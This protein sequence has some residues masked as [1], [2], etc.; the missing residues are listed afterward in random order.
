MKLLIPLLLLVNFA[1][2]QTPCFPDFERNY[3]F[4]NHFEFNSLKNTN[5]GESND[6]TGFTNYSTN[7]FTTSVSMGETYSMQV[8]AENTVFRNNRFTAWID[9]NNDELFS[10]NEVVLDAEDEYKNEMITIPVDS[11][12]IGIR[13][14]RV[15]MAG[16]EETLD[17][18]GQYEYGESEDYYITITD[19]YSEPYFCT[20]FVERGSGVTIEDFKIGEISNCNS[21]NNGYT[22]YADSV[23]TT[24]L[25]IGKTYRMLVSKGTYAGNSVGFRVNI[26]FNDNRIFESAETVFVSPEGSGIVEK[27]VSIPNDTSIIGQHRMRVRINRWATPASQCTWADGETEDYM[28]NIVPQDST[29]ITDTDWQKI[30]NF[31][32][33]QNVTDIIE[34]Y[35]N[36]YA[37]TL[38]DGA[39]R[40]ARLIK[41]SKDGDTLWSKNIVSKD[42][43]FY[44][45]N[46]NE[47]NGGG[48]II[49]GSSSQTTQLSSYVVKLDACGDKQWAKFYGNPKK[50]DHATHAIQASDSNYVVL[51]KYLNDTSR[52]ALAKLDLTG[53][54]IWQNDYTYH[55][56]SEP[57][58][59]IETSDKGF[60]IT[61]YTY[62]PN[63]ENSNDNYLRSM[64]IKIDSI[65]NTEWEK[66]LGTSDTISAAYSSVELETGGFMVLT[67]KREYG[68]R[69][70]I[71]RVD[72]MGNTIFHKLISDIP[73][74]YRIYIRKMKGDNYCVVSSLQNGCFESTSML[75]LYIIDS[76]GTILDTS[77]I[78]D[79]YLKI[80]GAAVT[81]DNKL[82]V[83]GSK[84]FIDNDE[85]FMF[86]FNED[87]EFDTLY[88]TTLNY[89]WLCDS[90]VTHV[91]IPKDNIDIDL[92][93]TLASKGINIQINESK[94][95]NYVVKIISLNG[96]ILKSENIHSHELKNLSL[97]NFNAG[98]YIVT[99][100]SNNN[101]LLT[102]KILKSR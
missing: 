82:I 60:L 90:T 32:E 75:G 85:I 37:I 73:N 21:G 61:G 6:I 51:F 13:R 86:K 24:D 53:T 97:K 76:N 42:E 74:T 94:H 22:F 66:V 36:G 59:L 72:E 92:Y 8:A 99:I 96:I 12:Y 2:S 95:L 78:E 10:S 23:F 71:Y 102:R 68:E 70:V 50:Y 65:G 83:A 47:T 19:S 14:L 93:P 63:Q 100:S 52:I 9:F 39:D 27:Y 28:V 18:C 33:D 31:P 64:I 34:T 79:H 57:C 35:D 29:Q 45:S 49:C 30:L 88:N 81:E 56:S 26:D 1:Y 16:D 101:V 5:S 17:P 48:F 54:V 55:H 15:M 77:F 62:T 40:I 43:Y 7:D 3:Y 80:S 98:I 91:E 11:T 89:D 67:S 69:M 87:L 84:D 46:I 38:M 20:P 4:I 44:P 25:E 58:D 41:F